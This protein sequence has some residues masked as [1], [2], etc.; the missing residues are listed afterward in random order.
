MYMG[1]VNMMIVVPMLIQTVTFGWIFENLLGGSGPNAIIFSGVLFAI[2]GVTMLWV[3]PPS[4]TE[5]SAIMPLG[6]PRRITAVYDRVVVGSDGTP[7]SLYTVGHAA[8]VAQAADAQLVVVSAYRPEATEDD[9]TAGRLGPGVRPELYGEEAARNALRASVKQ[10]KRDRARKIDQRVVQCTPAEALLEVAGSNPAN[11]I[12]VGNRGVGAQAGEVLGE[13]PREVV[14]K[15]V[16]N[17]MV[18]Q[19]GTG[20]R[21][22][23]E[24]DEVTSG[25]QG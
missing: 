22:E 6:S 25:P 17:V 4:E 9:V 21:V 18:V 13:V 24:R 11:L 8:G 7:A 5:E 10:L 1:I 3:N 23:P 2:G 19:T 20:E 15:A 12:V 16:C 14:R